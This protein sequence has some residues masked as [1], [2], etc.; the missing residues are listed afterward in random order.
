M[1]LPEGGRVQQ[2]GRVA[3]GHHFNAISVLSMDKTVL[4]D[5]YVWCRQAGCGGC[6]SGRAFLRRGHCDCP[7]LPGARLQVYSCSGPLVVSPL[8]TSFLPKPPSPPPPPPPT[9][10]PHSSLFVSQVQAIS[11]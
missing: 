1:R 7:M 11:L 9:N 4:V 3:D 6:G 10:P 8:Q 5:L 2:K